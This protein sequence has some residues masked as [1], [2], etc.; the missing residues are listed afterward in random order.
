MLSG[1]SHRN[2]CHPIWAVG[3]R[4]RRCRNP[5]AGHRAHDGSQLS[6]GRSLKRGPTPPARREPAPALGG[7]ATH[8]Q[9]PSSGSESRR[10]S[11][12]PDRSAWRCSCRLVIGR[13]GVDAAGEYQAAA[14][15]AGGPLLLFIGLM[16]THL[17]GEFSRVASSEELRH[18]IND[19][20]SDNA[21]RAS[22]PPV[23][24]RWSAPSRSCRSS[25][26]RVSRE[27]RS[28]C[29]ALLLTELGRAIAQVPA[30]GLIA[31]GHIRDV[32]N[33]DP[34]AGHRRGA[35]SQRGDREPRCRRRGCLSGCRPD[36][37]CLALAGLAAWR[38]GYVPTTRQR[39]SLWGRGGRARGSVGRSASLQPPISILLGSLPSPACSASSRSDGEIGMRS[40]AWREIVAVRSGTPSAF[41]ETSMAWLSGAGAESAWRAR[42]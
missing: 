3:G 26:P 28:G 18:E 27:P 25:T 37:P 38:T 32:V 31:R 1:C 4:G 7:D 5:S 41:A 23:R 10:V 9:N 20:P 34:I 6:A 30:I 12:A 13:L 22:A 29:P 21:R 39:L 42:K 35:G 36:P 2:S 33:G 16:T 24:R 19:E 8:S 14:A 17:L 40:G 15:L 11:S